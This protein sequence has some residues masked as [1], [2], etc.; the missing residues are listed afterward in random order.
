MAEWRIWRVAVEW[1]DYVLKAS[2][3]IGGGLAVLTFWRTAKVRRAEWLSNL[4]AK[5]FESSSY[6]RIRRVLDSSDVD[7]EFVQLK[8]DITD[9]RSTTFAEEFV[10]Y[11]NFFEFVASLRRLGQ[12]KSEEIAML[13]EYYLRLLRKHDFVRR[14]V[15]D[16]GFEEL[17]QLLEECVDRRPE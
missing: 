16:N 6:K 4:H 11:L 7:P 8:S 2:A 12:I 10:D 14:F 3:I 1:P 5:F 9:G 15:R 13:F 17:D